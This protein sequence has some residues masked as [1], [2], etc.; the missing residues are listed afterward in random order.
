M[1]KNVNTIKNSEPVEVQVKRAFLNGMT[2]TDTE[3]YLKITRDKLR[4]I[5]GQITPE[6]KKALTG[7][8]LEDCVSK[9]AQNQI[10]ELLRKGKT[11]KV[12]SQQTR[13]PVRVINAISE[14]RIAK[15]FEDLKQVKEKPVYQ[16][17]TEIT[18]LSL[19]HI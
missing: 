5:I 9:D 7:K 6:D 10:A 16:E 3:K 12:I 2:S 8:G 11:T 19:I 14:A 4:V 17:L 1:A 15:V 13:L 18:N